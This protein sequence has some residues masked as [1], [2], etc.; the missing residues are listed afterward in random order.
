MLAL[1]WKL[2]PYWLALTV[3]GGSIHITE[4]ENVQQPQPA[5]EPE[6]Y[7]RDR[8]VEVCPLAEE[9][10]KYLESDPPPSDWI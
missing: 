5:V 3:L 7:S 10:H 1:A 4:G 2:H 9:L 6:S 8:P